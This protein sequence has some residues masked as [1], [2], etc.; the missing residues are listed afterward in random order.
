MENFVARLT[1]MFSFSQVKMV[2]V[3]FILLSCSLLFSMIYQMVR[4][5]QANKKMQES[6]NKRMVALGAR[7]SRSRIKMFNY[8]EIETFIKSSGLDFMFKG[9]TP[10]GYIVIKFAT[11]FVFAIAGLYG[12]GLLAGIIAFIIGFV[13]ID[14]IAQQSNSGDNRQMLLDLK[15]VYDTLRIQTRAG[16]YTSQILSDCFMIVKNKRLRE[17][18]MKLTSSITVHNDIE[19]SLEE[20]RSKFSNDYIDSLSLIIRQSMVTGL[21]TQMLEDIKLQMENIENA[22]LLADKRATENKVTFVQLLLYI[23]V[24]AVSAFIAMTAVTQSM[25]YMA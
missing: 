13:F 21:S 14:F 24:I 12:F 1:E 2:T 23:S 6:Y 19:G 4:I 18:M 20:F 10:I 3:L 15:G 11:A 16:I 7:M 17:A 25:Q 5:E 9:L 8:N 22:L